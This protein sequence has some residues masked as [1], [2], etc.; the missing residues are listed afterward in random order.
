[1]KR[2]RVNSL[3]QWSGW[4]PR[5]TKQ[6]SPISTM[7]IVI[8][9]SRHWPLCQLLTNRSFITFTCVPYLLQL[10][11]GRVICLSYYHKSS[12]HGKVCKLEL[13]GTEL[14]IGL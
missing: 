3:N 12:H 5:Y 13:I 9:R 8:C 6:A 1:M 7:Q 4:W 10:N 14:H 2:A 11:I